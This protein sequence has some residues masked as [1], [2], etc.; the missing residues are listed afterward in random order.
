MS[1]GCKGNN[2]DLK[3]NVKN[4]NIILNLIVFI[5]MVISV[6]IPLTLI[7]IGALFKTIVLESNDV[8]FFDVLMKKIN[9][10]IKKFDELSDEDHEE[11]L[12]I[13]EEDIKYNE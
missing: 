2:K 10:Y 11:E 8:N 9:G 7:I 3:P 13:I 4:K 6:T 5:L 12:E 1:C